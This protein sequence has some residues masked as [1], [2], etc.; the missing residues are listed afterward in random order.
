MS[1]FGAGFFVFYNFCFFNMFKLAQD[2]AV[3][4]DFHFLLGFIE[5]NFLLNKGDD[6][7]QEI[8]KHQRT[9][10]VY[11]DEEEHNR[12][13]VGHLGG[14]EVVDFC[15]VGLLAMASFFHDFAERF[16]FGLSG[17]SLL[18]GDKILRER[19]ENRKSQHD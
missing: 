7:G 1:D 13:H 5:D 10:E 8:I 14:R 17:R 3:G 6:V 19:R 9:G 15:L 2:G 12:H 4:G 18:A 16:G 11:H